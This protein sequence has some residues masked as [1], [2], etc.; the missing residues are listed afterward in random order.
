VSHLHQQTQQQVKAGHK[1]PEDQE[2]QQQQQQQAALAQDLLLQGENLVARLL[3]SAAEQAF[4]QHCPLLPL[5][6]I[7]YSW[8]RVG[9]TPYPGTLV[10]LVEQY[11]LVLQQLVEAGIVAALLEEGGG[12]QQQ[13]GSRSTSS[14][15]SGVELASRPSNP[16]SPSSSMPAAAAA[17]APEFPSRLALCRSLCHFVWALCK[18]HPDSTAWEPLAAATLQ[19]SPLLGPRDLATVAYAWAAAGRKDVVLFARLA[20]LAQAQLEG[21]REQG[22][23]NLLWAYATARCY[24]HV[25]D[26]TRW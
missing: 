24:N 2:Q 21:F 4:N 3:P 20:P 6:S 25:S 17:A 9:Y 19:L 23:P 10:R 16:P 18:L 7:M 14:S 22:L 11:V 15:E 13:R 12:G 5:S 26:T 8:A 1:R